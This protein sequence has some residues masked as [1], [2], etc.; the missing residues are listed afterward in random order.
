MDGHRPRG[1]PRVDRRLLAAVVLAVVAGTFT[2]A[3]VQ[4]AA[5]L[6]GSYGERRTVLVAAH[7]LRPGEVVGEDAL[8]PSSRPVGMVPGTPV[9]APVGRTVTA[10]VL[11]GEPLVAE[12]L[13]PGGLGGPLALAPDGSRAVAVPTAGSR[14]PVEVG[15]LVDVFSVPLD[16][17]GRAQ[18]VAAGATVVHTGD[19]ATTVA[20]T[21][22][23]VPATARAALEQTAVLALVGPARVDDG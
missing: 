7:D 5:D 13:A 3:T 14:P 8:T 21:A 16:G 12:R 19:D 4:R 6:A 2:A 17:S 22:A 18:R 9:D 15:Q 10:L 23:E 20:V 1:R 11:E